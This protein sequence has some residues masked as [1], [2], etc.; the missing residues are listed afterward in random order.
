MGDGVA[1]ARLG[2]LEGNAPPQH[3]SHR[4]FLSASDL[5]SDS[6]D[7][8]VAIVGGGI[9]GLFAAL[10]LSR[11]GFSV[12][13]FEKGR[14]G[15]EQ[16]TRCWGWCREF[17][18]DVREQ[19]L[20]AKAMR[21][22]RDAG[23]AGA[24]RPFNESGIVYLARTDDQAERYTA[25]LDRYA[26]P[27]DLARALSKA[28]LAEL[29]P[30]LKEDW[31]FALYMPGDGRADP[32]LAVAHAASAAAQADAR[33]YTHCAVHGFETKAGRVSAIVTEH[34]RVGCQSLIVAAGAWSSLFC[35]DHGVTLPLIKVISS[36]LATEPLAA[37]PRTSVFGD[38]FS[39]GRQRDGGYL[40]GHGGAAE[41]PLGPDLVRFGSHFIRGLRQEWGFVKSYVRPRFSGLAASDWR[42]IALRW[43]G[44]IGPYERR[45]VLNPPLAPESMSAALERLQRAF[46]MFDS[47]R[48]KQRWAGVMDITPDAL[49]VMS[50]VPQRAGLVIGAGFSGHGFGLAPAAG[51]ALADL[52]TARESDIDLTPF[53]L[54]R[55]FDGS[56]PLPGLRF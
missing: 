36:V 20:A 34:G 3:V 27:S 42:D 9:I 4:R 11:R 53:R 49:P 14:L 13:L 6:G 46:P 32:D 17:G 18:R 47:V 24:Q 16:S 7:V 1:L 55:F 30:D 43:M 45:R 50:A 54:S 23:D 35:R 31:A 22:W 56:R 8:D 29:L 51:E 48:I 25:Y 10:T 5:A 44:G 41:L 37:A 26:P 38:G 33:I 40:V 15:G 19:P 39:F 52:A 12:A 28:E 2:G 21:M